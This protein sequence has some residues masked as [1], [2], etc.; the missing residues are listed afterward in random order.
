MSDLRH[1]PDFDLELYLLK[2]LPHD[3]SELES[4]LKSDEILQKKL[5]SLRK[6]N[7]DL[8]QK[9]PPERFTED[10]ALRSQQQSEQTRLN[11]KPLL[12]LAA[13]LTIMFVPVTFYLHESSAPSTPMELA[14]AKGEVSG[15]EMMVYQL[16]GDSAKLLQDRSLVYSGDEL[17]IRYRSD[18][19]R[20]GF[21][22][23]VDGNG[24]LTRH[25]PLQGEEAVPIDTSHSTLLQYAYKLDNAPRWEKFFF[26][27][28]AQ[29]FDL[30][31]IEDKIHLLNLAETD[32]IPSLGPHFSQDAFTL[33][34]GAHHE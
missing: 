11:W 18:G 9:F 2:E 23:S 22:F 7:T 15:L 1:F 27:A 8:L 13:V 21:I 32:S 5:D 17:Q 3:H 33:L 12:Q 34:K 29:P 20:F 24:H 6:S 28:S 25:L 4:R 10:L 31:V 30:K 16:V 26:V 19:S 14:R